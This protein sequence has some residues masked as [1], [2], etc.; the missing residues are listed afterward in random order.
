[1]S[2]PWIE[3]RSPSPPLPPVKAGTLRF[4]PTFSARDVFVAVTVFDRPC[5]T[6]ARYYPGIYSVV[7][8]TFLQPWSNVQNT[9]VTCFTSI[10]IFLWIW[11]P[12]CCSIRCTCILTASLS[13][14]DQL[15]WFIEL[16]TQC[17]PSAIRASLK[18]ALE[19]GM[20]PQKWMRVYRFT[21]S[22]NSAI[23]GGVQGHAPAALPPKRRHVTHRTGGW[24][25][26]RAGLD[27]CRKSRP[28]RESV[29]GHSRP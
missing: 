9:W 11:R 5:Y 17:S 27:G 4:G 2:V 10:R 29:H 1:M 3:P 6:P 25:G 24:A 13:Y 22:L 23:E 28:Y 14:F 8:H 15:L 12:S 20:K 19:Q 18:F 16:L 21:F 7:S 26:P